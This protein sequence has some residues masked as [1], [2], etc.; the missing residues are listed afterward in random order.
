MKEY[1]IE[2]IRNI[3][4]AGHGGSGKTSLAEAMLFNTGATNRLGS[5]DDGNTVSDYREEEIEHRISMNLTPL[6][7]EWNDH[8][9]HIL[10][11]PGYSDFTSEVHC[12]MRV[13][14]N[15]AIVVKAIEG[16]EVETE[17]AWEYAD[18][19]GLPRMVV[20]NLL[21][22]E[23][24]D[25]FDALGRLQ[26][27][28]GTQAVPVQIPIGEA[29]GFS[30]V[31]DLVAMKAV[32]FEGG[33]GKGKRSEIP[34]DLAD[35][36]EEQREKLIE[37][38]AESD[39]ELLEVYF[40]EG[41]LTDEQLLEGLR[42][43]VKDGAIFPVLATCASANIGVSGVMDAAAA[44]MTSPADRPAVTATPSGG[45][46]E[47]ALDPDP[48]GPLAALV[49]KTVSEAHIGELTYFRV[50]SGEIK[51][52]GDV[53]NSTKNTSERFGQIYH[54]NGHARNELNAIRAGEI[55]ATV[56]LKDTHTGDSLSTRQKSF[57]LEWVEFAE[58]VAN[59]AV[60]PKSK[61]DEEKISTGLSRLHEEDPSFTFRY[62]SEIKQ[63]ILAGAGEMHLDLIVER[64]SRRFGVE[65]EMVQP[66]I[67]YREA[68]KGKSEA[69]GRFKR[70]SGGRG[71][72]GDVW[73][74]VEPR[75]R[76]DG[77]EFDNGIVGGAVPSRFIPAVDKGIQEAMVEGVMAKYPVVDLKA[78]LYDGS[79]HTVD[80]S[81]MAFKVAA[82]MGF[83]KAFMEA[84]P[85]L[86]EPI[87]EVDVVVPEDYMGDV[88]GDLSSR[89]GRIL[90]M[91][92]RGSNQVV[93]AE[94]PLAE[95]YRY[96]TV[97][98]S[99]THGR[100]SHARKF[101]RYEEMPRE[102]ETK[103]IEESKALEEE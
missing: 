67:P 7:C 39:D 54:T 45:G 5:V 79:F 9:L 74:R 55:G 98:R 31:V 34:A 20:V 75:Q 19:Y 93:R 24:A 72:F 99:I 68:I 90:G 64:L 53:Y 82:S 37:T 44:Y 28:F 15:V 94:V 103:V 33:D 91:S 77:Y 60:L 51:H 35:Q 22:K 102:I 32:T 13:T 58:P 84:R 41:A 52:G 42:K 76:G 92:P 62:N 16:I 4:L 25:F 48:S 10:D 26:E 38:V 30:G 50:F 47:I 23:H 85:V 3:C 21:D 63:L 40:E 71:Q 57:G 65:V 36:A 61:D 27:R 69:Q 6:Y 81:E 87:Y 8:D 14:D 43:G 83:K 100:G 89:R 80:S 56:K 101:V 2:K 46:E 86:L 18:Q 96:S 59:V 78:T 49:F 17:R 97:L 11:T 12:A 70:Q 1:N 73:L 88:M 29:D 95:L 66:R